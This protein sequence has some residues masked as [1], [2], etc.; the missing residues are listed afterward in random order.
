MSLGHGASIVR[1]G[2]VL[3]LDA[4]NIKSYPGSGTSWF[5]I[6][7][8]GNNGTLSSVTYDSTGCMVLDASSDNVLIAHSTTFNF[9][10]TFTVSVWLRVNSFNTSSIYNVLSKKPSFNNTQKGWS[11]Q[12]DYRTTGVMQYRN[13]DGT[14]LNDSTPTSTVDNTLLLNQTTTWVNTVWTINGSTVTYYINGVSKLTNT[15]A[16]TNTD[17]TSDIYI[18]KTVGSIGD[19][20]LIMNLSQVAVYNRVLSIQEVQQNFSALR[21]RYVI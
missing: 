12:Y 15:A 13:N 2:L 10:S 19:P 4:A 7:G 11:C 6:S 18:G 8:R 17:T 9:S 5:D 16:Y 14:V 21:G 1:N 20:G 3:H